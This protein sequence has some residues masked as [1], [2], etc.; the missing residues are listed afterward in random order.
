MYCLPVRVVQHT[1]E[2][3]LCLGF[4]PKKIKNAQ[5]AEDKWKELAE[6]L[7]GGKLPHK[8]Y[9]KT[10]L[11]HFVI[12]EEVLYYVNE[13][14]DGSLHYCLVVPQNLKVKAKDHAISGHSGIK[15]KH[16]GVI[17]KWMFVTM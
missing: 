16:T 5:R 6:Y 7:K 10:T 8:R 15:K 4:M 2:K 17:W 9:P 13:N 3:A 1:S 14:S 12:Q 11:D